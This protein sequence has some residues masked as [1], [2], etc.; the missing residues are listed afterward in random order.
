MTDPVFKPPDRE[1]LR[2]TPYLD[3]W[4]SSAYAHHSPLKDLCTHPHGHR[5]SQAHTSSCGSLKY[6]ARFEL[7]SGQICATGMRSLL[8]CWR[9]RPLIDPWPSTCQTPVLI[10]ILQ[11]KGN[12]PRQKNPNTTPLYSLTQQMHTYFASKNIT[13][14]NPQNFIRFIL[15]MWFLCD[16]EIKTFPPSYCRKTALSLAEKTFVIC[17]PF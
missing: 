16:L 2:N 8:L 7:W 3:L 14:K 4:L 6:S 1:W 17:K 15:Q 5:H 9:C 10:I 12:K 13:G 11:K